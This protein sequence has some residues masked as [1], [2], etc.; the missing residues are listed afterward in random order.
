MTTI[1]ALLDPRDNA[2]RYVGK[3]IKPNQRFNEHCSDKKLNHKAC[4]IRS[5]GKKPVMVVLEECEAEW[6]Q[7]EQWWISYF[8]YLG[9]KLVNATAGGE[10]T[11]GYSLPLSAREKIAEANRRRKVTPESKQKISASSV[12]RTHSLET[13]AKIGA[14]HRNKV[15]SEETKLKLRARR[16]SDECREK[17]RNRTFSE[18]TRLKM[19]IAAKNRK[20][21]SKQQG[22]K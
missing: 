7:A 19:S 11:P 5:L 2:I 15:V 18:E 14:V 21:L 17:L 1:Y 8:K 16:V 22:E 6:A 3:T 4:W 20:T 10:G 9:A 13:K 12:G